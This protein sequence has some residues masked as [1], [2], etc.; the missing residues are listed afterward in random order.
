MQKS[1]LFRNVLETYGTR[2][3]LIAVG[4]ATTVLVSRVLGPMGRGL[5]AVAVVIGAIGVQFGNLGLHASN[6]YYVAK[7]RDLLP[8]LIGNTLV[9]SFGIGGLGALV[10]WVVFAFW[11]A[12]APLQG[13]LLVLAL[14]WIPFGLAYMLL[15]N[16]LLGIQEV[17]AY[18]AIEFT[19]K[20]ISLGLLGLLIVSRKVTVEFLFGATLVAL[21]LSFLWALWHLRT[22]LQRSP[23]P[24]FPVFRQNI[25]LGLKAYLIAFFGFLVLRI[26][27]V[28]VKYILGAQLAGYY[29]ISETMAENMLALPIVVGVIL[30]PRLSEMTERREKLH[31]MQQA[32]LLTAA[33]LLPM[34]V[35]AALFAKPI[36]GLVF[37]RAFLPAVPAFVWLMPG[38]FFLG[39][40]IVMV[41]YLNSLGFPRVI[42]YSW[43]AV[44]VANIGLNFWAIPTYGITGAAIVSTLSYLLIFVLVVG[45]LWK[46]EQTALS[47]EPAKVPLYTS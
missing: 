32:T 31:L 16:L 4:L 15:Q 19:S 34:M 7:D 12:I 13:I 44:T 36:V 1:G 10:C 25:G 3:L 35:L 40:E 14:A 18:N 21:V 26:D 9:I 42:V 17:R 11:P 28:M 43:I 20:V 2:V 41:Q 6:T 29:S 27:L 8:A 47:P 37:G 45:L 33:L 38:S 46:S 22:F 5:F 24:S 39:I 23:V 30:F